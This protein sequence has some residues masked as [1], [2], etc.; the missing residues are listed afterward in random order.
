M[1]NTRLKQ[2]LL[3]T[4]LSL[5]ILMSGVYLAYA[6]PATF[7][8]INVSNTTNSIETYNLSAK[9]ILTE[10]HVAT[11]LPANIAPNKSTR[12]YL[13]NVLQ[14]FRVARGRL[15]TFAPTTKTGKSIANINVVEFN[16]KI[17]LFA[18]NYTVQKSSKSA[19]KGNVFMATLE[20]GKPAEKIN[21]APTLIMSGLIN[22]DVVKDS[23]TCKTIY[24]K[25]KDEEND[26]LTIKIYLD[27]VM[28]GEYKQEGTIDLYA[29][30]GKHTVEIYVTDARGASSKF[31]F[32]YTV[33]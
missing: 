2:V 19:P 12:I 21:A 1:F 16:G 4:I 22:G 11:L 33:K 7:I 17:S 20:N 14:P 23:Q 31:T 25:G 28:R 30:S 18:I 24:M 8:T 3:S 15:Y 27:G 29:K 5:C 6:N 32:T 13:N 10:D 26:L 9:N